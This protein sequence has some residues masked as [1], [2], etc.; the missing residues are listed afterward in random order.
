VQFSSGKILQNEAKTEDIEDPN[1]EHY[2]EKYYSKP[3]L[4]L[5]SMIQ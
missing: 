4:F 2:D 1:T 5:P 3:A